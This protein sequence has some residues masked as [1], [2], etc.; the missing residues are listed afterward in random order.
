MYLAVTS[1]KDAS[2][3]TMKHR[4]WA[5]KLILIQSGE[6]IYSRW[7]LTS[8]LSSLAAQA[9]GNTV[10]DTADP[11]CLEPERLPSSQGLFSR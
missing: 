10:G 4:S 9:S 2:Q 6:G 7:V 1:R 11:T 5:E 3:L 8:A